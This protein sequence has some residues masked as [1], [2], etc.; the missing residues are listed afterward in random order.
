MCPPPIVRDGE[1]TMV[2]GMYPFVDRDGPF[3]RIELDDPRQEWARVGS[4]DT[5]HL[6]KVLDVLHPRL[7]LSEIRTFIITPG[8]EGSAPYAWL[9]DGR[10]PE[11]VV[12]AAQLFKPETSSTVDPNP[13]VSA[14]VLELAT[15]TAAE[16]LADFDP[17]RHSS[18][19]YAVEDGEPIVGLAALMVDDP[20][21]VNG[22]VIEALVAEFGGQMTVLARVVQYAIAE[23]RVYRSSHEQM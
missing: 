17:L 16:A 1:I 23:H 10:D 6:D 13:V 18:T 8:I 21:A 9:S 20:D 2:T 12:A 5:P 14:E 15:R 4:A 11:P 3:Y 7:L 22:D 19:R